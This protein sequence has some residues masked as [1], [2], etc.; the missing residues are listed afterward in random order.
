MTVT[1]RPGVLIAV[2]AVC[3]TVVSSMI[4]LVI[5]LMAD[6]PALLDTSPANASWLVTSTLLVAAA[7]LPIVSKLAD[8]FGKRRLLIASL[9]LVIAGSLLGAAVDSLGLLVVSRSLQGFG[10]AL[11]PIS[12]SL[13]GEL[14]P[15][16]MLP[17]GIALVQASL[18]VGGAMGFP[19]AGVLYE[20]FGW[21]SIFWFS[22]GMATVALVGLVAVLPRGGLRTPG[23]FDIVGSLLLGLAIT[24]ILIGITQGGEWGWSSQGTVAAFIAGVVLLALLVPWELRTRTPLVDLRLAMT[25]PVLLTNFAALFIGCVTYA[26][27]LVTSEVLQAP[28]AA[29]YG[30]DF[31]ARDTGLALLPVSVLGASMA[32]FVSILLKHL[33][34]RRTL[35]IG[36]GLIALTF[37][38]RGFW[39]QS[40]WLV[41]A[42][43]AVSNAAANPAL[44][45]MP[46]SILANVPS[47]KA[48]E[49]TGFNTLVQRIGSA[50]G[51]A[52]LVAILTARTVQVHGATVPA[53]SAAQA[54]T[55][56]CAAAAIAAL[57]C[58]YF[59]PEARSRRQVGPVSVE[60]T[61]AEP[62]A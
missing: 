13:L 11:I 15:A 59:L 28:A 18:G 6:F 51:S 21:R 36:A 42:F 62:A 43:A 37:G 61:V 32:W 52:I 27:L 53:R 44:S 23:R 19:M 40:A 30:S 34:P 58:A 60:R 39:L 56:F 55:W 10:I 2:L 16:A 41:V 48:S 35:M 50:S 25:R 49:S 9:A 4:S 12:M 5:P 57:V 46:A 45:A 3:G 8:M 29:G 54:F 47:T 22:A 31:G 24:A 7:T 14:L 17:L 26:N 38:L 33:G 20:A 1:V